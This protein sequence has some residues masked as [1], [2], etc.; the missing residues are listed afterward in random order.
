MPLPLTLL[1]PPVVE[2][3]SLSE[4]KLHLRVDIATD[5][6]LI[7][8]L[9]SAARDYAERFTGRQFLTATWALALDAWPCSGWD[10]RQTGLWLPK[11]P[12]QTLTGTYTDLLGATQPL[13]ITYIDSDGTTQTLAT[14][15]YGVDTRS[16]PGRIYL[17]SGQSWPSVYA[18]PNAVQ[19]VYKAGWPTAPQ[20]YLRH[21]SL[22][23][24]MLLLVAHLYEQREASV[25]K[26]LSEIPLGVESLL[27]MNRLLE[28][29]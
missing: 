3:I 7:T 21:A 18:Q 17:K 8:G 25:E 28:V 2:P 4:A 27:W 5:D 10:A 6:T 9:I 16:E 1:A 15:V 22:R 29:A 12:L 13:G 14:T 23:S 11:P 24:A 19:V 26:A 20:F